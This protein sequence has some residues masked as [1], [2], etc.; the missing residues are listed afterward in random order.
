[1]PSRKERLSALRA[2]KKEIRMLLSNIIKK[3]TKPSRT[4]NYLNIASYPEI[5]SVATEKLSRFGIGRIS[6]EKSLLHYNVMLKIASKA[7]NGAYLDL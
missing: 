4:P 3:H 7:N 2:K 6:N 5:E 1:M